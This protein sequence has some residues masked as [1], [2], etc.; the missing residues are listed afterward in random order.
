MQWRLNPY[1]HHNNRYWQQA[2]SITMTCKHIIMLPLSIIAIVS[3]KIAMWIN[4][5]EKSEEEDNV[6]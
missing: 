3:I 6:Q 5:K 4:K 2:Q 1:K